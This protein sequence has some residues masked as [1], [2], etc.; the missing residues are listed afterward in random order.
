M[1]SIILKFKPQ[2]KEKIMTKMVTI[3]KEGNFNTALM[4]NFYENGSCEL[5]QEI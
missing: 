5:G 2:V 4:Q 3:L 1:S